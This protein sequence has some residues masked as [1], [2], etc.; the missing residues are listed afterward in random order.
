MWAELIPIDRNPMQLVRIKNASK[1]GRKARTL[2]VEEFHRLCSILAEP[3]RTV[4]IVSVCLGLRWS[5]LARLQWQD[6]DGLGGELTLRR[7][8]AMQITG[9]VKT[10][11]SAKPLSLD[12]RL[13]EVLK[14]HKQRSEYTA[15]IDWVFASPYLN[16]KK[17]RSYI[18][19]HVKLGRACQDAGIENVSAHSFR[20][21]YRAWLDE[22][23]TPISVQQRAMRH[24]DIRAAMNVYGDP[25]N[26]AL[27]DAN[28]KNCRAGYQSVTDQKCELSFLNLGWETGI[29]PATVGATVRCSAS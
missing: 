11:H 7:A 18:C 17:P 22:L 12:A 20:H 9:E 28:S 19:F 10:V 8:L 13:L 5:E 23:G 14:A 3:Y 29:E 21:S 1:P 15:A 26:D 16:G 6:I 24:G 4:A 27:K 25:V 2:R